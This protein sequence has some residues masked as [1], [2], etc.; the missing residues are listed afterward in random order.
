[1]PSEL[2]RF[3]WLLSSPISRSL[4]S[5]LADQ[6][7]QHPFTLAANW[8]FS[9]EERRA[10]TLEGRFIEKTE[11]QERVTDPFGEI[12]YVSRVR[13]ETVNFTL[14]TS[15]PELEVR[16][17]PASLKSFVSQLTALLDFELSLR[18]PELSLQSLVGHLPPK[19]DNFK[20]IGATV[21]GLDYKEGVI[22]T[23]H[24][25]GAKDIR[26]VLTEAVQKKQCRITKIKFVTSPRPQRE[27]I[28]ELSSGGRLSILGSYD[29]SL[30]GAI[31][32]LLAPD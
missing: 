4:I 14:R 29:E 11:Y 31:R 8:G 21:S 18:K 28:C 24:L 13:Y 26:K 17:S 22:G 10:T 23:L 27:T 9:I 32:S 12:A 15:S 16:N 1:M 2:T 5:R 7:A 25:A 19:L 20:L 3:Q 6:M 30:P